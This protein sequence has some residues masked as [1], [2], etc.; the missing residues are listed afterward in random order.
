MEGVGQP[1]LRHAADDVVNELA[2]RIKDDDRLVLLEQLTG[3]LLQQRGLPHT[4]HAQNIAAR[5]Q[6]LRRYGDGRTGSNILSQRDI[7]GDAACSSG[8]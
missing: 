8:S 3:D 1:V 4:L 7:C 6:L 2:V 5:T